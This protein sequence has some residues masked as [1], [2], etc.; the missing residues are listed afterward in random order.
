MEGSF[1]IPANE[2]LKYSFKDIIRGLKFQE[3]VAKKGVGW[4][5]YTDFNNYFNQRS[6]I[7]GRSFSQ[8]IFLQRC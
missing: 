5:L 2:I 8:N 3:K 4:E 6:K 7:A 1:N